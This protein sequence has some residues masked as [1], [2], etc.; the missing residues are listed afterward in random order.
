M[1]GWRLSVSRLLST[2]T[3]LFVAG[4][5]TAY[6][7]SVGDSPLLVLPPQPDA[8]VNVRVQ[9][10]GHEQHTAVGTGETLQPTSGTGTIEQWW[11]DMDG[12]GT[13]TRLAPGTV[14]VLAGD[15]AG[16]EDIDK[17]PGIV[18]RFD[19]AQGSTSRLVAD[20][21]WLISIVGGGGKAADA[22]GA[23]GLA[24]L[25]DEHAR[26]VVPGLLR[27]AL[28]LERGDVTWCSR[29]GLEH[30]F[31]VAGGDA[32]RSRLAVVASG[33]SG[34]TATFASGGASADGAI[35]DGQPNTR[36]RFAWDQIRSTAES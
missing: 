23:F 15:L 3:A 1:R 34:A 18:V 5:G 9:K 24:C 28:E 6:G 22:S 13:R 8:G 35:A 4:D 31:T 33:P 19:G 11:P 30:S 32:Q 16:V 17:G 25:S 2:L 21:G 26:A 10:L 14:L 36:S 27:A 29:E 7:V 20:S 12:D